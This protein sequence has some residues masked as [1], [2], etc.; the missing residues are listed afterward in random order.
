MVREHIPNPDVSAL[1]SEKRRIYEQLCGGKPDVLFIL[2]RG[3]VENKAT[4]EFKSL[5]YGDTDLHGMV[6]GA[7]AR[8][9]AAAELHRFF[10][11]SSVVANSLIPQMPASMARVTA[12]ELQNRGVQQ[13]KIII[14]EE[15]YSTFTELIELIKLI[16]QNDWHNTVVIANEFHIPRAQAMLAHI[17]DLHDP[18][19]YSEKPE[20]QEA[21]KKFKEM[22]SVY[23]AFVSAEEVLLVANPHYKKVIDAARQLPTWKETMEKETMATI[24]IQAGEYWRDSPS[25][26]IK[27]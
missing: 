2:A 19:G 15:S 9:I 22:Q 11:N 3:V 13:E 23:I 17:N 16:V 12:Q 26:T 25:T 5:G 6:G 8:S 1:E 21:L 18:N 7:K 4:G 24:Q 10:P 20:V 14:Q 27:K